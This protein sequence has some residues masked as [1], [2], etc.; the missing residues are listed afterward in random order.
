VPV[1]VLP[2]NGGGNENQLSILTY[3]R[4]KEVPADIDLEGRPLCQRNV[5]VLMSQEG[6]TGFPRPLTVGERD[7]IEALL[8]AVRSGVSRYI[9]QLETLT[10]VGGCRCG[11]P[12]IDLEAPSGDANGM[13]APVILGDAES[14]E[15]VQVGVILWARGG[16]LSGLEVHPWD[17]SEIIRLPTP[18]TLRNLRTAG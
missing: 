16:K 18:E 4:A 7:L 14:P 2:A 1:I 3:D 12:S 17:G 15:G 10:V 9:G 8:G 13:P 11:C 5:G 6:G